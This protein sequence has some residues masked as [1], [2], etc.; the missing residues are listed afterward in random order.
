MAAAAGEG[1]DARGGGRCRARRDAE[2]A[3]GRWGD[4]RRERERNRRRG[5]RGARPPTSMGAACSA[6]AR[7]S[8]SR[9]ARALVAAMDTAQSSCTHPG[10]RHR[11]GPIL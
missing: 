7:T 5:G 4:R 1:G 11:R 8:A 10:H 3:R 2:G 9:S 6:T